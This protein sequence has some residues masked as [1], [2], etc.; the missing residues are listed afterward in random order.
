MIVGVPRETVSGEKRV[1]LIPDLVPRIAKAGW[2][3]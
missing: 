3:W 2:R 1:A